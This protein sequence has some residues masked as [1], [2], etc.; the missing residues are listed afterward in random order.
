MPGSNEK[1]WFYKIY[2]SI[3]ESLPSWLQKILDKQM[4]KYEPCEVC[5]SYD[6]KTKDHP[7]DPIEFRLPEGPVYDGAAASGAHTGFVLATENY[8]AQYIGGQDRGSCICFIHVRFVNAETGQEV[9]YSYGDLEP[10]NEPKD[11]SLPYCDCPGDARNWTRADDHGNPNAK[12]YLYATGY[13]EKET[14]ADGTR[15]GFVWAP[16][17]HAGS[18]N[19]YIKWRATNNRGTAFP[20]IVY[21]EGG[22]LKV[23]VWKWNQRGDTGASP[24]IQLGTFT[25]NS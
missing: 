22:T 4:E 14:G 13:P 1:K 24:E 23:K 21:K 9:K 25:F 6:H 15:R 2:Q 3:R 7:P 8:V 19:V 11:P 20:C 5:G 16:L 10:R 17:P 18:W 12:P